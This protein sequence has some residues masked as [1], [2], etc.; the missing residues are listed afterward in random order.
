MVP[1]L[2]ARAGR[3][4]SGFTLLELSI[5]LTIIAVM[6]GGAVAMFTAYSAKTTREDTDQRMR[7]VEN[8]LLNYRRA[9]NRIPCPADI[10][11]ATS[12]ANFGIEAATAGTCTGGT[13]AA[14]FSSGN[15]V[16]GG[17]PTKTLQLPDEYAF[18]SWGR[19]IMYA[20]DKRFTANNGFIV[21]GIS[22]LGSL[23]AS[24]LENTQWPFASNQW[25]LISTAHAASS[26]SASFMGTDT[27][28]QGSWV[29]VYGDDGY[30]ISQEQS[31][32]PSYVTLG[33]LNK[34]DYVWSASTADV[35]A[36]QKGLDH[37]DRI[38]AV[39]F[40]SGGSFSITMNFTD[41]KTHKVTLYAMDW[42][43][44]GRGQRMDVYNADTNDLLDSQTLTTGT[45]F[46]NGIYLSW[47][48]EG[49]IK[50]LITRL[51]GNNA[52]VNGIFFSTINRS[53]VSPV[54]ILYS[55]GENG[56]GAYPRNG[57]NGRINTDITNADELENCDCTSAG[58]S[59]AFNGAY[60]TKPY[61]QSSSD[62]RDTFDDIVHFKE[63][64]D[65]LGWSE[66]P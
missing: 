19:R 23:Q 47:S 41:G 7:I 32:L 14:N 26:A 13:P 39:W 20:V 28:T 12:V 37:N 61:S 66:Q 8:A 1:F 65:L 16:A 63:R 49:N 38:A 9:N 18:D 15:S 30:S 57:G 36:L 52:I 54:Y 62:Q 60:V 59:G 42:P 4:A 45:D 64:K 29:G 2:R 25:Q 5:V 48:V 55:A 24:S 17:V 27:S 33:F 11:L 22:A 51:T 56:H 35:R 53:P 58:V 34:F 10:T 50:F 6:L 46:V 43:L 44:Q 3:R 31:N 40:E 21:N